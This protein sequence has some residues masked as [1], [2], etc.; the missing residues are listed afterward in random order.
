MNY[1]LVLTGTTGI[2]RNLSYI[3][4]LHRYASLAAGSSFETKSDLKSINTVAASGLFDAPVTE[5]LCTGT[6]WYHWNIQ[7]SAEKLEQIIPV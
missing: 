3:T 7:K 6:D 4:F 2:F 1:A 5:E